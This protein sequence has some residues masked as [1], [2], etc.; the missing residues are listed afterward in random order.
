L[1]RNE[2]I[3]EMVMLKGLK[4]LYYNKDYSGRN[5]L[6]IL[7]QIKT[8]SKFTE[9]R[10]IANNI[11]KSL[12]RLQKGTKAPDFKLPDIDTG[13]IE[14][15]QYKNKPV[16]LSF[17]TTWSYGCLA[18]MKLLDDLYEKYKGQIEFV[19]ISL[20]KDINIVRN[21]VKDKGY[22]WTFL[23]NG[24]GYD[25]MKDYDIKTF[26]Y[27]VLINGESEIF[28]YPAYKP[29]EIIESSFRALLKRE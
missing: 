28:H 16:Y 1:L 11:I 17:F 6:E 23:Y 25:L 26:P 19:S 14:L 12:T 3:R 4:E 22:E 13:F 29:S 15:S 20:D 7:E 24:N 21:Y 27:F 10:K 9:H 18:E 5:I 2:V 8:T